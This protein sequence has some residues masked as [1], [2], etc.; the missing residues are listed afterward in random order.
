MQNA[1]DSAAIAAGMEG[2]TNNV[3][4]ARAA[5]AEHGF[6]DGVGNVAVFV[7]NPTT[8]AGCTSNC[9]WVSVSDKAPL[10]LSAVVGYQGTTTVNSHPMTAVQAGAVA[11]QSG[12]ATS[13]NSTG[14]VAL[15]SPATR[16]ALRPPPTNQSLTLARIGHSE[17]HFAPLVR[18]L[19]HQL[20]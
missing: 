16:P 13:A 15:T 17:G 11:T 12:G 4:V 18:A 8:A 2:G 1:A 9:Y 20:Q 14:V 7:G 5:A 3:A 6:V 19:L 10:F